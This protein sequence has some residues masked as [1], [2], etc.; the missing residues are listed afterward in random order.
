VLSI[1]HPQEFMAKKT[2]RTSSPAAAQAPYEECRDE[3]FQHIMR[4]GV[5]GSAPEHQEEW[6]AE[7]MKYLTDRYPELNETQL[8]ELRTLGLRFAQ[9]PKRQGTPDAVTAA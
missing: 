8:N 5:I 9:P 3:L 7:T 2:Q 1:T 6:F 4:C